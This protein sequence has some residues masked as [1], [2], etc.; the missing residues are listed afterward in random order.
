MIFK[1]LGCYGGEL[2]GF[3]CPGFLVNKNLL[4]EAGTATSALSLEEQLAISAVCVSHLHLD[5]VKELPFLVENRA[6]RAAAPL[7]VAATARIV[8]GLRRDLF[9]GRLWPDFSRIPTR[10]A[11][12]L[13]YRTLPEGRFSRVAGLSIRPVRVSHTV[14]ATGYIL[15]EPGVSILFTGDTGPT[16]EVWRTARRLRDLRTVIVECSFPSGMEALAAASGHL[17]PKLLERELELLGRPRVPVRL[18]H[19]KPLH[20]AAIAGELAGL[21]RRT[22]LLKQGRTYTFS[23]EGAGRDA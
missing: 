15:R 13:V 4:L 14:D 16:T 2:P 19:M 23:E 20:L 22:T 6:V 10:R 9:N 17:T 1:V 3:R 21:G 12:A 18:C 5:H 8:A 11:P 7:I